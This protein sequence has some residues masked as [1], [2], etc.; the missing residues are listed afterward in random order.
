MGIG[1]FKFFFLKMEILH[2][3]IKKIGIDVSGNIAIKKKRPN[4][5]YLSIYQG[6]FLFGN[7]FVF[8]IFF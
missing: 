2:P 6:F 8:F 5:V 7:N 3:I 1:L 4:N